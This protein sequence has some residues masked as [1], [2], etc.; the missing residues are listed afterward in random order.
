MPLL[1][2]AFL[3]LL[4]FLLAVDFATAALR[5]MLELPH[6]RHQSTPGALVHRGSTSLHGK[7]C[8]AK[9]H[10]PLNPS[11][12]R[13][14]SRLARRC[15]CAILEVHTRLRL[16]SGLTSGMRPEH[17]WLMMQHVPGLLH[18]TMD[19][20]QLGRSTMIDTNGII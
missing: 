2:A 16:T 20:C 8:S 15:L 10:M 18:Y 6:R 13:R 5:S 3:F 9:K 14:V 1:S 11:P 19:G 12:C 17:L 4:M 7:L